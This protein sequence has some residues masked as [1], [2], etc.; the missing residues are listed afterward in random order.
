MKGITIGEIGNKVGFNTVNNGFLG[1]DN[2]RIPLDQMLMKNA[3]VLENGDYVKEKSSIL[4]YGTMTFVRVSIVR[5]MG[6]YLTK[7]ATIATRYS[8]VRRQSPIEPDK[9]EPKIIEHVTQQ[10]KIFPA[11]A[12]IFAIRATAENLTNM[13]L[14]VTDEISK[15]N[16]ARLPELH[17]LS[18]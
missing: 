5:D 1:F 8:A 15:G 10:M 7:A 11:I 6:L 16:L 18:W 12:K 14:E 9:P 2:V 4:T 17:A 13:Y 3:K